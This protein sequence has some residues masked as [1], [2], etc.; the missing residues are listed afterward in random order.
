MSEVLRIS[1]VLLVVLSVASTAAADDDAEQYFETHVRPLLVSRCQECHGPDKQQAEF[2][3]DTRAGLMAGI[4]GTPAI[5]AGKPAESRLLQV[6]AYSEDDTQMPPDGKLPQEEI[7]ILTKWVA[8]GAVWPGGDDQPATGLG[9][10]ALT[11]T[12]EIDFAVEA[13]EHW[14]YQPIR[15]PTPPP[16]EATEKVR[17]PIDRFVLARLEAEGLTYSP[18]ADPRTLLRRAQLDLLGLPPAYEQMEQF[19][20]STS[21]AV[22]DDNIEQML[23]SPAYGQRWARHWLDIARYADTR[24]YVFTQNPKYPFA[25]T[26]RDYVVRAFNDDK[27]FDRF[28]VEQLAADRL[29]LAEDD[30]D[31]AALGFLTVGRRF[32][33]REPDIIDDRIDV[34][35]RGF[36]GMTVACARCH[37]HKYDPIPTADYYSLYGVFNSSHEPEDLPV[38]GRPDDSPEYRAYREEL[39]KREQ[40]VTDYIN[41]SHAELLQQARERVGDYLQAV[42]KSAGR[43]PA[44]VEPTYEHG[45]PREK[46]TRLW[47][48]KIEERI[49]QNDP[50]FAA[51]GALAALPVDEFA[52]RA[53]ELI[54]KYASAPEGEAPPI[55][56]RVWAALQQTPPQSMLEVARIYATLLKQADAEWQQLQSAAAEGAIPESLPDEAAEQLRRV[57]MGPGS[58][59]DVPTGE[60]LFERDHRDELVKLRR[61]VS[62]WDSESPGA[63]PRAMVMRDKDKPVMPVVFLR[64]TPGRNGPQVPRRFPRI[65]TGGES[66]E[67]NDG[68]GRLELARQIASAANPLTA[69]VIVNRVWRH[70]FGTG[71]VSTPSDF[72]TRSDPPT[73]PELLDWLA[74]SLIEHEWSLKWL[75]REITSSAAYRQASNDRPEARKVD[76]ENR[77]LWRMNRKRL[78]FEPMRDA[79]LA[80]AGRLDAAIGGRPVDIEA[81]TDTGRRSIYA[82]IDRNNFSP[83]LRTFDYPSPDVHSSGRPLTFVPQQT[84][85]ALNAPFP[86][87]MAAHVVQRPPVRDAAT[88]QEQAK[89]LYQIVLSREPSPEEL[90]L[91]VGFLDGEGTTEQLAQALL[92]TNEFLFVD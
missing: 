25:Y 80:V 1:F 21:P 52:A 76:P 24:G 47:H 53:A 65:L 20:S 5:V 9:V 69:R 78:E 67:F 28:I 64:G 74:V 59:T 54:N 2:R 37:D 58:V 4:D 51:W 60:Q 43:L 89:A 34:V 55:N 27:P 16:V 75:H 13:A 81:D 41:R 88:A 29:G 44:G 61:K 70:H 35:T 71:L 10:F 56:P 12:G 40:A 91:G 57:L 17:S 79:M 50:V 86:Q 87:Q 7:D 68:S 46:L 42:I 22:Y 32:L 45:D 63:P 31:L 6:L 82:F 38:I 92:L 11:E 84:L 73:H 83:L 23:A 19:V 15:K 18:P 85:Y 62:E 8:D 49:K 39:A 26:Y 33:N 3:L 77:L 66:V 36:M 14:S 30:P 48:H 90:Q 72:G